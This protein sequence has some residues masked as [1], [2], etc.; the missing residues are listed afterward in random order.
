MNTNTITVGQLN[1]YVKSLIEGDE[2]LAYI[3]VSGEISN[4][5]SHFQS[6]HWYFTLKDKDASVRCVMFKASNQKIKFL[7][8]DGEAVILLGR[9]SLYEKDGQYQYGITTL[10]PNALA[11]DI[12]AANNAYTI[13][14][15][16]GKNFSYNLNDEKVVNS[17]KYTQDWFCNDA[18]VLMNS[19]QDTQ[20]EQFASG[21]ALFY[22]F[23]LS[24]L[25][26]FKDMKDTYGI[27]PF[28]RGDE[29]KDYTGLMNWNTSLMG[30]PSTVSKAD[31]EAVG[32]VYEALAYYSKND[33]KNRTE[34]LIGRYVRDDESVKM[35]DVISSTGIHTPD[36]II[37]TPRMES[38]SNALN[39]I[40][41]G[42]R[43]ITVD[44]P[45]K[46]ASNKNALRS[47][48]NQISATFAS[49]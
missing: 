38:I 31:R 37:A 30:I 13:T 49:K 42:T 34:E 33:N 7:P 2:N 16:K 45:K 3:A 20:H 18:S 24:Y 21:K 26:K 35:L 48:L 44:I 36:L 11:Q 19:N 39:Q 5:K 23:Q 1:L 25:E 14:K 17:L 8:K 6:G 15:T 46:I 41:G 29:S 27:V 10:D 4:F 40:T 28:P 22:V 12:L 47:A 43:D 32:Y 9:V